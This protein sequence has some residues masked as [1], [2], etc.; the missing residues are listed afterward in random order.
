MNKLFGPEYP[1][2]RV[3]N[4]NPNV[5]G[6][7]LGLHTFCIIENKKIPFF[8]FFLSFLNQCDCNIVIIIIC[9]DFSQFKK[10]QN[11]IGVKNP[12]FFKHLLDF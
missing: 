5:L 11:A 2:L 3:L 4:I 8:I 6:S 7:T 10:W 12:F 1:S 9:I